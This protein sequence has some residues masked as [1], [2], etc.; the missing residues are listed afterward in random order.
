MSTLPLPR[1]PWLL[2]LLLGGFVLV[3]CPDDDDDSGGDDDD[4]TATDDDD[5]T[6][7][8]DLSGIPGFQFETADFGD[9]TRVDRAGMPAIATA[10]IVDRDAYNAAG[11]AEDEGF[12]FS[13]DLIG[14]LGALHSALDDD[15]ATAGLV[16]CTV[17]G[18]IGTCEAQALPFVIPDVLGVDFSQPIA[19][20]NGRRLDDPV[21]DMTLALILLDLSEPGQDLTTLL[22][23]NPTENDVAFP[24]TFPYLAPAH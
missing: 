22:G 20:P 15:L 19:F 24:E 13:D 17:D 5:T 11:P 21:I 6:D 14:S 7:D 23:M 2:L 16:P 9:Y 3:G 18:G 1:R 4:A 8:D 10:L 12:A